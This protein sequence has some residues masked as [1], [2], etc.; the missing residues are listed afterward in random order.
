[1]ETA[2]AESIPTRRPRAVSA[3]AFGD[4]CASTPTKPRAGSRKSEAGSPNG[5]RPVS[6]QG[7]TPS[8]HLPPSPASV[9][10]AYGPP[11]WMKNED[12]AHCSAGLQAGC[13]GGIRPAH[14][15]A[16]GVDAAS[17]AGLETS[18][19]FFDGAR[20]TQSMRRRRSQIT[21][22][23]D[24]SKG[25]WPVSA[26]GCTSARGLPRSPAIPRDLPRK[27]APG[28]PARAVLPRA[29]AEPRRQGN[30]PAGLGLWPTANR[31]LRALPPSPGSSHGPTAH[32]G[33]RK[34]E[35]PSL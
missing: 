12:A 25:V 13:G 28:S 1:M 5:V 9:S 8:R 30:C 11:K 2:V 4:R 27:R 14:E 18:A 10:W 22:L 24:S 33:R 23:P 17:T 35:G 34:N 26:Q 15:C 31:Q 3:A 7:C 19:T 29:G 6:A 32:Q 20:K 16:A 21:R